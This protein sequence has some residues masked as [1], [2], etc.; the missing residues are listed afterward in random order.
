MRQ[1]WHIICVSVYLIYRQYFNMVEPGGSIFLWR[2]GRI[3]PHIG[4]IV[5]LTHLLLFG[6]ANAIDIELEGED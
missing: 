3:Y 2:L 1:G 5:H 4:H 6:E